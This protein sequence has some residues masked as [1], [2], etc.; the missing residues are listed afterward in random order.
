MKKLLCLSLAALVSTSSIA[1][2]WVYIGT[3]TTGGKFY[4]DAS[5]IDRNGPYIKFWNKILFKKTENSNP[6]DLKESKTLYEISCSSKR[7]HSISHVFIPVNDE[8][9]LLDTVS[10]WQY[11]PP[12]T[13]SE[14]MMHKLCS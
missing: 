1:A 13:I 10:S 2:D 5:S 9:E 8:L 14:V 7:I 4:I 3:N 6:T 12:D 11:I